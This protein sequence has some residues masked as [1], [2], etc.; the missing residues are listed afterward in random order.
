M[1]GNGL[2][3]ISDFAKYSRTTRDTLLHYDKI[4]L[5]AATT[6]GGNKYRYYSASQLAM[7]NV[8]RTLQDL[9]MSLDEI[10][11]IGDRRTPE[12]TDELFSRQIIK[13]DAKIDNWI[14]ARK[15][16]LTLQRIIHSVAGVDDKSV[17]IQYLPADA[18][19]LGRIND[20]SRG[21]NAYDALLSF[22]QD[23]NADYPN[24]D[25]N[26]PVWAVFSG[27]RIKRNDWNWPDRYYFFNPDG[28]DKRPAGLYAIGFARGGYGQNDEMYM[29]VI[30]YIDDNGFEICGDAYEEYPLNEMTTCDDEN[31]LL[32][33]MIAV[34]AKTQG[35]AP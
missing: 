21:R 24:L 34:R 25:L 3:T 7:V 14:R 33:V 6:R 9:G 32:R 15:L 10:R 1:R 5:L 30:E 12:S 18:I 13:I 22:Y 31:Y 29:R 11:N 2:F 20:Y 17:T 8:I 27:E 23:V 28:L 35:A 26:Y 4:G 19:I 16:L